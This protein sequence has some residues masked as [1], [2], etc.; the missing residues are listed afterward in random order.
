MLRR[1]GRTVMQTSS[2]DTIRKVLSLASV[3]MLA[4][5]RI[6]LRPRKSEAFSLAAH[7]RG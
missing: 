1:N 5:K 3:S 6:E 4:N 2:W 7:S